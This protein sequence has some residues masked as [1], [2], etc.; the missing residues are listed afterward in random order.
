M[1][2]WRARRQLVVLLVIAVIAAG[3]SFLFFRKYLPIPT[4]FDNK[5]NQREL[6]VD[7]DG[8]CGPCELKSPK[9]AE[10]FWARAVLTRP[11]TYD[12]AVEIRNPN[13][14]LSSADF[15]YEFTIFDSFGLVARKVGHT[16]VLPQERLHIV[17][18]NLS[19]T[20]EP[21]RVEFKVLNANWQFKNQQPPNL[22]VERR[23]YVIIDNGGQKQS[24]VES[25]IV[26]R[27]SFSFS[28]VVVNFVVLDEQ[29]NLLG[30]NKILMEDFLSGTS[31]SVKS[32]WPQEFKGQVVSI[33]VE[34]R[35]NFF[36]PALIIKPR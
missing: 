3:I 4:C 23:D 35:V 9:E 18:A 28:K 1:F 7:C 32:L 13:E 27:S 6:D 22:V 24:S 31:R 10:V 34:P 33:N 16:F 8:P 14:V 25:S 5:Q 36:D 12:V 29:K 2:S 21:N 30:A 20:R 11:Q 17:E 26:N 15:E 19:T